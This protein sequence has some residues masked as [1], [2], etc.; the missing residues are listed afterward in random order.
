MLYRFSQR[1][2]QRDAL[3]EAMEQKLGRRLTNNEIAHA[4]HHSRDRKLQGISPAQV[5]ARQ[6][7]RLS[8]TE[9]TALRTLQHTAVEIKVDLPSINESESIAF[10]TTHVFEQKSVAP[11]HELLEAA[12]GHDLGRTDLVRLCSLSRRGSR[13]EPRQ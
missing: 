4:V 8:P 9:R 2:A 1:S 10:A 7:A 5:R 3:V 6:L 13:G 11:E 12:L